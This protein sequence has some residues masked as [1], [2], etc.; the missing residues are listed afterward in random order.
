[1]EIPAAAEAGAEVEDLFRRIEFDL[2]CDAEGGAHLVDAA[3]DVVEGIHLRGRSS[4]LR[5]G[6][7]R[8]TQACTQRQPGEE[9]FHRVPSAWA[10]RATPSPIAGGGFSAPSSGGLM[11]MT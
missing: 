3:G 11:L 2:G 7:R 5:S 8:Q 10:A 9:R 1:R 4:L 6:C